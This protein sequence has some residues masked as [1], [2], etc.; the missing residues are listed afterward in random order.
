MNS[1]NTIM[2]HSIRIPILSR[3]VYCFTDTRQ[4]RPTAGMSQPTSGPPFQTLFVNV[5][6]A[7]TP[8]RFVDHTWQTLYLTDGLTTIVNFTSSSVPTVITPLKKQ[9]YI[10]IYNI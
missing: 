10:Y 6:L 9:I 4:W 5:L 8:F 3:D 2:L 7:P 1:N